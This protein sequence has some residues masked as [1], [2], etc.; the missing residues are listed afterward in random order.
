M[1]REDIY[2]VE[3]LDDHYGELLKYGYYDHL[4]THL[5]H[6]MTAAVF[7]ELVKLVQDLKDHGEA[8]GGAW[9]SSIAAS[10]I[11][12][13]GHPG[14]A[15][16]MPIPDEYE[17]V[18]FRFPIQTPKL[19]VMT[20]RDSGYTWPAAV[21]KSEKGQG[22]I[23][24]PGRPIM[25]IDRKMR[26]AIGRQAKG[27]FVKPQPYYLP[28][29]MV[30]GNTFAFGGYWLDFHW[31]ERMADLESVCSAGNKER[32]LTRKSS[33]TP[34]CCDT[35][36]PGHQGPIVERGVVFKYIEAPFQVQLQLPTVC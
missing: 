5:E 19:T 21:W 11:G 20:N 36:V 4:C 2:D 25:E 23:V 26:L 7:P 1:N 18:L 34:S 8:G 6:E 29:V 15:V 33:V 22:D 16:V 9:C 27:S 17:D 14:C 13:K 12:F 30:T 24:I 3:Y 10:K 28:V 32:G 31:Q 35:E